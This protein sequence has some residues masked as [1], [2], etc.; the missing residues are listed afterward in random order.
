[1]ALTGCTTPQPASPA[2]SSGSSETQSSASN[3][4]KVVK[5]DSVAL[6][7]ADASWAN[8]PAVTVPT[9]ST[10]EG[11]PDGPDVTIQAA[12][13]ADNIA[14]R[15]EWADP[16][17]TIW[18][19]PWHWDGTAWKR[20]GDPM[21][22][23]EDRM[24]LLFPIENNPEFS[25]KGCAGACHNSDAD[26]EKWWMGTA[27]AGER[28]DLWQWKAAQTNPVGHADD[29]S[30]TDALEDPEDIESAT[31]PDAFNSGGNMPNS[32]KDKN[33]PIYMNGKDVNSTFIITGEQV[34]LDI[35]KLVKD[36]RIPA[37]VL[38]FYDGSRADIRANGVWKDGKWSVVLVR[39]LD[40]GNDDDTTF[41]PPKS[42]PF[43]VAVFDHLDLHEH[44]TTPDVLTLTWQ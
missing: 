24:A 2:A 22:G 5:V 17:E 42:Y 26:V 44:T 20:G 37:N 14:I 1:M 13:D 27:S 11:K 18:A 3:E 25:S 39:A 6:D 36:A 10:E 41:T 33:A 38:N 40:T 4:V 12:Y 29:Y 21:T 7:P 35:S 15:L 8:A 16:T 28:L 34:A 30:I 31:Y 23:H 32:N 19:N 43:G 9:K